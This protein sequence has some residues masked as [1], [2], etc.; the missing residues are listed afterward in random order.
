MWDYLAELGKLWRVVDYVQWVLLYQLCILLKDLFLM[1]APVIFWLKTRGWTVLFVNV[2]DVGLFVTVIVRLFLIIELI[3]S[4]HNFW[5]KCWHMITPKPMIK[6]LLLWPSHKQRGEPHRFDWQWQCRI[7]QLQ[8][9]PMMTLL[10]YQ[11]IKFL[12]CHFIHQQSTQLNLFTYDFKELTLIFFQLRIRS[13]L[14]M[15]LWV[16][17]QSHEVLVYYPF[18]NKVAQ[19]QGL[20]LLFGHPNIALLLMTVNKR[21]LLNSIDF[22]TIITRIQHPHT[23]KLQLLL[24]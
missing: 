5:L 6:N 12:D 8:K 1:Y 4:L 11:N 15:P 17:S 3:R 21:H 14:L 2:I 20:L 7:S 10:I 13:H 19:Q 22:I 24:I 9:V 16:N 18:D 23:E